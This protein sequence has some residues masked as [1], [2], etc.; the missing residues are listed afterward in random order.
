MKIRCFISVVAAIIA[1]SL[2]G[3][4]YCETGPSYE[5]TVKLITQTMAAS[6]S[7]ARKETYGTIN[8][9][10]CRL[11]YNV[12]GTYPVG[13]LYNIKNHNIDFSS[14]NPQ[15]SKTDHDYTP[16]IVLNFDSYFIVKDDFKD[17]AIRTLVVNVSTDEKTQILYKA[18]LHLGE[19]CASSKSSVPR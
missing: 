10:K 1:V 9:T 17:M 11:D 7:D 16:F 19:L 13:E 15:M 5:D 14:L 6:T 2:H 18:F 8:F 12:S 4:A 3:I